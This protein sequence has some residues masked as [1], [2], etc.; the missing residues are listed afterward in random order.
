[1]SLTLSG[2]DIYCLNYFQIFPLTLSLKTHITTSLRNRFKCVIVTD[3]R[4]DLLRLT[5]NK[6]RSADSQSAEVFS[7]KHK[8]DKPCIILTLKPPISPMPVS[9][10]S[11]HSTVTI[12]SIET[13]YHLT[14]VD[15]R[16][17]RTQCSRSSSWSCDILMEVISLP[18]DQ[19]THIAGIPRWTPSIM[20]SM[21]R[22]TRMDTLTYNRVHQLLLFLTTR[23]AMQIAL[24]LT[25]QILDNL[26]EALNTSLSTT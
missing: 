26:W 18:W 1:M 8:N 5:S 17:L 23:T 11:F 9:V 16:F 7:D 24:F 19:N 2:R 20:D 15:G 3:E 14:E 22:W 25:S 6:A 21:M 13:S 10:I 12:L 4:L